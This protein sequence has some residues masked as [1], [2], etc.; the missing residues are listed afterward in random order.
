MPSFYVEHLL[1]DGGLSLNVVCTTSET[2]LE[3]TNF[4]FPL[5]W[6]GLVFAF[7]LSTRTLSGLDLC[8]LCACCHG[9]YEFIRVPALL[10]LED[11]V[12]VVTSISTGSYNLF[13]FLLQ[14][15]PNNERDKVPIR[16]LLPQMNPSV[17]LMGYK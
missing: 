8:R 10:Y 6:V 16:H 2:L 14:R 1:L 5:G 11:L 13:T 9:L 7:P 4:L 15:S 3:E 17:P 12:S